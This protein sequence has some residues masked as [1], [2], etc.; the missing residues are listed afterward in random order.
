MPA[1]I[2]S[3]ALAA[4]NAGST[5][6]SAPPASSGTPAAASADTPAPPPPP[7]DPAAGQPVI[8]SVVFVANSGSVAPQYWRGETLTV[9]SSLDVTLEV[10]SGGK[11]TS[12]DGKITRPQFDA[13]AAALLAA[14]VGHASSR[15]LSPPP[16]GGGSNVIR[17]VTDRGTFVFEGPTRSEFP[18]GF[19]AI[20]AQRGQLRPAA[21]SK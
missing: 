14:D 3:L 5:K 8:Q 6:A 1:L 9:R 4:C 18:P 11:T 17:V 2:A 19:E 21:P 12:T 16:V 10:I 20:F 13:L 15:A 7:A